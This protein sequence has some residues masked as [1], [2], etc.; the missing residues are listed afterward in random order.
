MNLMLS[1][2]QQTLKYDCLVWDSHSLKPKKL[3][4]NLQ[5]KLRE[6]PCK[7]GHLVEMNYVGASQHFMV[8][9]RDRENPIKRARSW[10]TW[11]IFNSE[12]GECE[13]EVSNMDKEKDKRVRD[14]NCDVEKFYRL[15]GILTKPH[16]SKHGLRTF[17]KTKNE[18]ELRGMDSLRMGAG[19]SEKDKEELEDICHQLNDEDK[20][21]V[22]PH[23]D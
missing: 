6:L 16:V 13:L 5:Q 10:M 18:A 4:D 22:D 12:S 8:I 14:P 2:K 19:V 11:Y 20:E 15:V 17:D 7:F 23:D 3:S 9:I 1:Q 21:E